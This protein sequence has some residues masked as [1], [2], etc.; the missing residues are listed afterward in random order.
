MLGRYSVYAANLGSMMLLARVFTPE[1]FGIIASVAVFSTFFQM[2]SEAGLGPSIIN[3]DALEKTD[4]NGIFGLTVIVGLCVGL[5]FYLATPIIVDF[6]KIEALEQIIPYTSVGLFFF[7]CSI[8]PMAFLL[9]EQLFFNISVIGLASEI[10]S[11]GTTIIISKV[12]DPLHA[13][14]SK[15]LVLSATSFLLAYLFSSK[16][17]FGRPIFGTKFSAI[18]PLFSFSAYQFSFNLVNYFTRN[19]DN[20]LVA[21]Y[22]GAS[23]LGVYDKAY[24]IMRYPLMLLTFAMTPAIQPVI[25]KYA[26]D[27]E[28][29]EVIHRDFTF[30]L[31]IA[32]AVVAL[33]IFVFSEQMVLVLLGSSWSEVVPL[34]KILALAIPVQVVLS[35]SGSFFQALNRTDLLFACGVFSSIITAGGIVWGIL[36]RDLT[37]LS[38]SI[39]ITFHIN[40]ILAYCVLYIVIFKKSPLRFLSR[41]LP[42]GLITAAMTASAMILKY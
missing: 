40:F 14:A 7:T 29:V 15:P 9:R 34:I 37:V 2:L 11:T 42:A 31:S 5:L 3:V 24:Q 6:Y 18:K 13:L 21:K 25:R 30:K 19:L 27:L 12:T 35:T 32:G 39:V 36:Q 23:Y 26:N 1:Q 10:V 41:M 28:M 16:T 33:M 8:V 22:M 38:W 17:E 4:R 20:I